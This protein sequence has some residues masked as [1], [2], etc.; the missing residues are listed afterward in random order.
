M[1]TSGHDS[2]I[3][4]RISTPRRCTKVLLWIG[5]IIVALIGIVIIAVSILLTPRN[6]SNIIDEL[7]SW[8]LNADVRLIN[9]RVSVWESFPSVVLEAD[10]MYVISKS[11]DDIS[12]RQSGTLP[13]DARRLASCGPLK[14]AINLPECLR[15]KLI[16]N[17]LSVQHLSL[18]LLQLSE[19]DAN[20][21]ILKPRK[22]SNARLPEILIKSLNL[23]GYPSVRF[24]SIPEQI[25]VQITPDFASITHISDSID[26]PEY[27]LNIPGRISVTSNGIN[28]I[29]RKKFDLYGSLS[30]RMSPLYCSLRDF[31]IKLGTLESRISADF[32]YFDLAKLSN[33]VV[34]I[35]ALR[36]LDILE[37]FNAIRNIAGISDSRLGNFKHVVPNLQLG[38]SAKMERPF[39]FSDSVIPPI[40]VVCDISP[41]MVHVP[42]AQ[43][44]LHVAHGPLHLNM[45]YDAIDSTKTNLHVDPFAISSSGTQGRVLISL[46]SLMT[47]PSIETQIHLTTNPRELLSN[48]GLSF[49]KISGDIDSRVLL[50]FNVNDINSDNIAAS[51]MKIRGAASVSARSIECR[52]GKS[53]LSADSLNL[54]V[55]FPGGGKTAT[56]C[57]SGRNF[58]VKVPT[59][60]F[61]SRELGLKACAQPENRKKFPALPLPGIA[62]STDASTLRRQRHSPAMLSVNLPTN[63]KTLMKKVNLGLNVTCIDGLLQSPGFPTANRLHALDLDLSFDSVAIRRLIISSQS[64]KVSVRGSLT[65][66]RQF[67]TS[68]RPA[69]LCADLDVVI[70]TIQI[71]QLSRTYENGLAKRKGEAATI[72]GPKVAKVSDTI[73]T[74]L[75]RNILA[76]LR[77]SAVETCY[78]NLR[79]Y[80]LVAAIALANGNLKIPQLAVNSDF[81]DAAVRVNFDT[82]NLSDLRLGV[83]LDVSNVNLVEFYK[84]FPTLLVMEPQLENVRGVIGVNLKA[85]IKM[86]PDMYFNIPSLKAEVD[87]TGRHLNVHQSDFIRKVTRMMMIHTDDNLHIADMDVHA[88]VQDNL[89]EV[90]PFDFSFDRYLLRMEGL[91]NFG[92]QLYYHVGVIKSPIPFRFGINIKNTFSDPKLRFGGSK[93]KTEDA[94]SITSEISSVPR[95]NMLRELKYYFR[96][97][98][99]KAARYN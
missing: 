85:D 69:L 54:D 51:L 48:L 84:N 39:V 36:P 6:L 94:R 60:T 86:Y 3:R 16:F 32:S 9:P 42:V 4:R 66:L 40:D 26:T 78:R 87:V 10:S 96:I 92:G 33:L 55:T 77:L 17:E 12:Q 2:T 20:Y 5:G 89:L 47:N 57:F 93:F 80:N 13:R 31:K 25:T 99:H 44:D 30:M 29:D 73:A 68:S 15:N 38:I 43:S 98:V 81:C 72:P 23:S 74:L 41:G 70:D 67:L 64:S 19:D 65:N 37:E 83:D 8:Y 76:N 50:K 97:F 28:L 63:I 22:S 14:V 21:L 49:L 52:V 62:D 1:I 53:S 75:P 79:F 7:S 45:H 34:N 35:P 11:L 71:N 24:V 27:L 91:N 95:V 58:A 82:G 18:N 56:L 46:D 90:Y 59:L 88:R 61:Y